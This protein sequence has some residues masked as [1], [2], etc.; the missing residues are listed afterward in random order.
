MKRFSV[1]TLTLLLGFSA[2]AYGQQRSDTFAPFITLR[3]SI[4][5]DSIR[6]FHQG[7]GVYAGDVSLTRTVRGTYVD[8]TVGFDVDNDGKVDGSPFRL[9][10]GTYHII[11]RLPQRTYDIQAPLDT[12][13]ISIFGSSVSNG[14]GATNYHGY[15]YQ[16]GRLLQSRY[17]NGLSS[18]PFTIS[19]IAING[20]TTKSLLDRY[21]DLTHDFGRYVIFGLSMGN[22]GIHEAKDKGRVFRQF[23]TNM[24]RLI[25]KV[26]ADGKVP[27]VMNNYTRA[28]YNDSDY[29]YIKRMNLLIH[30]WD[31][32]SVNTLGAID[33]GAGH[34]AKDYIS[35]PF[36]PNTAG[37]EQFMRAMVPSLF[38]A[39]KAGKPL[40][41]RETGGMLVLP[42]GATASFQA[43]GVNP[44]AVAMTFSGNVK[45]NLLRCLCSRGAI[46]VS[47]DKARHLCLT[48]PEGRVGVSPVK[49]KPKDKHT[50]VLTQYYARKWLMLYL[51]GQLLMGM[52]CQNAP[53]EFVVGDTLF[54]HSMK[55][56][57]L[58]LWRSALNGDEVQAWQQG[59]M[60][61]S[62]LELYLPFT[63]HAGTRLQNEA[64]SINSSFHIEH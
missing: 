25:S 56:Y 50:L 1:F 29:V 8:Q 59:K 41:K 52:A 37:H 11:Y 23:A 45:G 55:L 35:D 47:I 61:Q 6:L 40:A 21:A 32:P 4:V 12:C 27:V 2:F 17:K 3:G 24:Q 51:D 9:N 60:L 46:S 22:E 10:N 43:D 49:L 5:P 34:W 62:S 42:I 18:T 58:A 64:Q 20:N 36:H 39:I 7:N 48:T 31:V 30:S 28:D 54:K 15:A 57:E 16:Y 38:D 19:S 63:P 33:D 26:R 14:V 13:R 44:F 53:Y